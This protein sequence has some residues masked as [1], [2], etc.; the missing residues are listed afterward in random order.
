MDPGCKIITRDDRNVKKSRNWLKKN[1]GLLK[2]LAK[3]QGED[4]TL[5]KW[6]YYDVYDV[7]NRL[8]FNTYLGFG[9]SGGAVVAILPEGGVALVAILT[10]GIP[11]SLY[12]TFDYPEFMKM[13]VGSTLKAI[14]ESKEWEGR[15]WLLCKYRHF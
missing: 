8:I 9:G 7:G 3:T 13:E 2:K 5:V 4:P 1:M 6:A 15:I 10:H 11:A 14:K 12:T